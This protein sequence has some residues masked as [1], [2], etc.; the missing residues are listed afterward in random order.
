MN[1]IFELI[2]NGIGL[3][4]PKVGSFSIN[5][6]E[7][8]TGVFYD[9]FSGFHIVEGFNIA[10]SESFLIVSK[11][12]LIRN[13]KFKD[14]SFNCSEC[15]REIKNSVDEI[16]FNR[17]DKILLNQPKFCDFK[18]NQAHAHGS[19][20]ALIC[21]TPSKTTDDVNI[22][23]IENEFFVNSLFEDVGESY[24]L[25]SLINSE[26]EKCELTDFEDKPIEIQDDCA[27]PRFP[28][29]K[30]RRKLK[31]D[32]IYFTPDGFDFHFNYKMRLNDDF[33][34]SDILLL[35]RLK[36]KKLAMLESQLKRD[37]KLLDVN[38]SSETESKF[39]D[40]YSSLGR[41]ARCPAQLY[42]IK[43]RI[44]NIKENIENTERDIAMLEEK[45]SETY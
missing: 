1:V 4:G 12:C 7:E 39:F 18:S 35:L 40:N 41:I 21:T 42:F 36:R 23:K 29:S 22:D 13:C 34:K 32:G 27:T 17:D 19:G 20:S 26:Q 45:T 2:R 25:K 8:F 11:E 24:V 38:D 43:R 14:C 31:N 15:S 16:K 28:D 5:N 37:V 3:V 33:K 6:L 9:E 30:Y 10:E 44:D